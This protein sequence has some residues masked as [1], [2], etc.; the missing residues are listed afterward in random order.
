MKCKFCGS[1]M[2]IGHQVCRMDVLVG[3]VGEFAD[4]LPG[5]AEA[6]IY[7]SEAPYGPFTCQ[8]CGAEY[9]ELKDGEEPLSGPHQGWPK[10]KSET[11]LETAGEASVL[12]ILT[13][14]RASENEAW[15]NALR[16]TLPRKEF[17]NI[18]AEA[19]ESKSAIKALFMDVVGR[20]LASAAG[21]ELIC[22]ASLDYN[23]GDFV[24]DMPFDGQ[25][26]SLVDASAQPAADATCKLL[27]DQDEYIAPT[28][29]RAQWTLTDGDKFFV[30]V[31]ATVN[32]QDGTVWLTYQ[33]ELKDIPKDARVSVR[34]ANG[35]AL[36]CES[37]AG[38][39]TLK[40]I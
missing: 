17:E 13:R 36:E 35:D 32:F 28:D 12:C 6:N 39:T 14:L 40:K 33:P 26:I 20:C 29:V 22:A 24:A 16:L 11:E 19:W 15:T 3:E 1:S 23:W 27:V 30:S 10:P 8:N 31:P 9:E 34:L 4:N 5:G 21:W 25:G 37:S 38:F 2:F 7:D 18:P